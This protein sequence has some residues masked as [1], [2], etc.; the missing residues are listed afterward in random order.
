[1]RGRQARVL[2]LTV[3][4]RQS[5]GTRLRA[6]AYVPYLESRGH[7]VEVLF[8]LGKDPNRVRRR[9]VL[10]PVEL[11]RDLVAAARSDVVVVYR[12]TFPGVS[13][14]L[15]RRVAARVIYEFDDAVYLPSPSE[16]RGEKNM[17]RYRGN[18]L[19]TINASDLVVAGNHHLASEVT[20]R[21]VKILPTGVDLSV[22]KP[23]PRKNTGETCVLGWIGTIGNLPEWWRLL[24][25]FEQIAAD[26]PRV[27]FKVVS[28]GEP[29]VCDLPLIFERF[30][31]ER[32]ATCLEDFDIG[33][34]PLEDTPWNRGKCS[35][36]ALQC[37]AIGRPVVLS[38][39]GMNHEVIEPGVSGVFAE[40]DDEWSST[41]RRLV[42]DPGMRS[43]MGNAARAVVEKS[44]SL[45]QI[46]SKMADIVESLLP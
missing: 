44:Y 19:S 13:A 8:P 38:P 2:F 39:V 17:A 46:G 40:T 32:E 24:P 45:D 42:G 31:V 4:D 33:L 20:H 3:G 43:S 10:R 7:R 26:N 35:F 21:R 41:L 25:V 36:K 30:T 6:L 1:M 23:T 22:F 11:I 28:N 5:P 9:H 18:F 15:L 27:R 34:M 29:P 14:R 37:M 12:K 16:P